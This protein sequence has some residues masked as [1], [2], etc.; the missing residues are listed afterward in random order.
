MKVKMNR[1]QL[2]LKIG[3]R[4]IK[5]VICHRIPERTIHI[6]GRPLP[7]CARCTGILIGALWAMLYLLF[8]WTNVGFFGFLVGI[9]LILPGVIDGFTQLFEY[10]V[11]NNLLRI[12]TGLLMG[13]GEVLIAKALAEFVVTILT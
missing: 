11:S 1:G 6:K 13:V 4:E 5:I 12:V 8:S 2:F 7:L 9:I 10:R 3:N